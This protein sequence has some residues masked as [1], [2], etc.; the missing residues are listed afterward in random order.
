[1]EGNKQTNKQ[2]KRGKSNDSRGGLTDWVKKKEEDLIGILI[3]FFLW[4][5]IYIYIEIVKKIGTCICE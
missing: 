4:V 1:M 5:Y 2:S 3:S